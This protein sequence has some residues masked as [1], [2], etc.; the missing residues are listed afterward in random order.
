MRKGTHALASGFT[1]LAAFAARGRKRVEVQLPH[2]LRDISALVDSQSQADPQ[3]RTNRLYTRIGTLILLI[4]RVDLNHD[5]PP[6]YFLKRL[7]ALLNAPHFYLT[8]M[9]GVVVSSIQSIYSRPF[10][11]LWSIDGPV[12]LSSRRETWQLSMYG[13]VQMAR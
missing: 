2:L 10:H 7:S 3:C 4:D 9:G 8:I 12:S 11:P 6:K 1:C 5:L 13:K